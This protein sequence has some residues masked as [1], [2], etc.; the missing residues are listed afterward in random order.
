MT[1]Y[2][3][4]IDTEKLVMGEHAINAQERTGTL[5]MFVNIYMINMM[6]CTSTIAN[7]MVN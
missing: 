5:A 2:T 1:L 7:F 4:G 3:T 6:Q